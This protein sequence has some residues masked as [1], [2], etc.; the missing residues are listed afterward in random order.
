MYKF[1]ILGGMFNPIHNG[2]IYVAE[3]L[4]TKHIAS[5]ILFTPSGNHPL[6]TTNKY[7]SY[8]QRCNLVS[9]AI[10]E[11]S[12]FELS[13]LDDPKHGVNY[14]FNLIQRI[15]NRHPHTDFTFV[16][17]MDNALS[18]D[19][20]YKNEWLL[21]NVNFTVVSRSSGYAVS[22]KIDPRFNVVSIKPYDISSTE[23][24]SKLNNNQSVTGLVP[25]IITSTLKDYWKNI[26]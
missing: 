6:K 22:Q 18:F 20:W 9:M 1:A 11:F 16:I 17:G 13:D 23:V 24:R 4:I 26:K 10:S 12:D 5:K 21:D 14:T 3:Q 19:K 2:H 25:Q 15:T 8:Q 7:L